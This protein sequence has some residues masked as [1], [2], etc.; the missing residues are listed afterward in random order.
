MSGNADTNQLDRGDEAISSESRPCPRCN[1]IIGHDAALCEFCRTPLKPAAAA[2]VELQQSHNGHE[3]G[4]WSLCTC[5]MSWLALGCGQWYAM[6]IL[7]LSSF[8]L[9]IAGLARGDRL[10]SI[11]GLVISPATLIV[12]P[13]GILLVATL[14]GFGQGE[15]KQAIQLSNEQ[16]QQQM[17]R[18]NTKFPDREQET[19]RPS[20]TGI[21][22]PSN[23]GQREEEDS[24]PDRE[25]HH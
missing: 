11:I 8:W 17:M 18:L 21:R 2:P 20:R 6:T 9:G 23:R 15:L 16:V 13:M 14:F 10:S 7:A 1:A 3:L 4:T 19:G 25:R 5:F 24:G 12:L 22:P